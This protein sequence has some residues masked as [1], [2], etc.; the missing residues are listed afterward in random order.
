MAAPHSELS[1]PFVVATVGSYHCR[2]SGRVALATGSLVPILLCGDALSQD[3]KQEA[4]P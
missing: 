3:S 4:P 1:P 2:A